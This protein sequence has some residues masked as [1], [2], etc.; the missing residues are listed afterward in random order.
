MNL[1]KGKRWQEGDGEPELREE[2]RKKDGRVEE[3][4]NETY[5]SPETVL[6]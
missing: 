5:L 6:K 1:R 4:R 3:E 2:G